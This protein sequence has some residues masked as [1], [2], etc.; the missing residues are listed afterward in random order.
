MRAGLKHQ[1]SGV[2]LVTTVIVVAVLAVVAV[3]FMQSTSTDRLS[4][5]TVANYYKAQLAAK[6]GL[7]EAMALI[8]QGAQNFTYVS[9]AE[10]QG[11][12][13]RTYLRPVTGA[14]GVW[15]F[16]GAPVYLD[17]GPGGGD[18]AKLLLT[19]S[20]SEP[21][22][23]QSA[24][25]KSVP[26]ENARPNETKRYAFWVDDAAGKQNLTWWGGGGDRGVVTNLADVGLALP[27][28]QGADAATLPGGG[29]VG[30]RRQAQLLALHFQSGW[31]QFHQSP[32]QCEPALGRVFATLGSRGFGRQHGEVF[33]HHRL[34]EWCGHADWSRQA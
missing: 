4:S 28:A 31:E 24:A 12:S 27:G 5:R 3:A 2:A 25:W 10:V 32:G 6:A 11:G 29:D 18:G 34:G 14:S 21:G 20:L 23:Q 9:A 7:A 22:L 30:A 8:Q 16:S 13:Y 26:L 15:E 33:F 19:G 17:S 1:V